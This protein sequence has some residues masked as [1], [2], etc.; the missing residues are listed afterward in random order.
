MLRETD[1]AMYVDAVRVYQTHDSSAHVGVNHSIGCDPVDYPT[2]EWIKGHSYRYMRNPP[3]SFEDKG[4]YL[5][6]VHRGGG[7]CVTDDDCG[8][9]IQSENLTEVFQT[10]RRQLKH[11]NDRKGRGICIPVSDFR[12]FTFMATSEKVCQ[13]NPGYTG[14]NCL[15]QDHI[16]D[17]ESA[18]KIRR[19]TS[20]FKSIPTFYLN[21]FLV[22]ALLGLFACSGV[23][24]YTLVQTKKSENKMYR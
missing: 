16:D 10:G 12:S 17:T 24:G 1:V 11:G 6:P 19:S 9:N 2:R 14:P 23:F 20:L 21:P 8:G 4:H 22:F 3:F 5:K 7:K 13:C 18:Y 15:A